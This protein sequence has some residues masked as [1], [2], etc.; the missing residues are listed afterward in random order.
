MKNIFSLVMLITPFV[1]GTFAIAPGESTENPGGSIAGE[2]GNGNIFDTGVESFPIPED[3]DATEGDIDTV[4]VVETVIV[5][6]TVANAASATEAASVAAN[7]SNP[8]SVT[9][10]TGIPSTGGPTSTQGSEGISPTGASG[11]NGESSYFEGVGNTGKASGRIRVGSG[12]IGS[13][14]VG[15]GI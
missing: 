15:N 7:V 14:Q 2:T 5:T 13:G 8:A 9:N 4:T 11:D 10:A 3:N 6:V 1:V 12:K